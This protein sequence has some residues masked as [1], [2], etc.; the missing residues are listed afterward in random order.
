MPHLEFI[1]IDGLEGNIQHLAEHGVTL[2]EAPDVLS[3][4]IATD[5]CSSTG[6]SIAFGFTGADR[7]LAVVYEKIDSF[8]VY[9]ITAYDVES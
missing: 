4:P 6:R 7:K 2:E 9:V 3:D 1:W 5:A 8:T